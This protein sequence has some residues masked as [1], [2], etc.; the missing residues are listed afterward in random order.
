MKSELDC[1]LFYMW[2]AWSKDECMAIFGER[3]GEHIWNKWEKQ[4]DRR[5]LDGAPAPFYA[6]CDTEVRRKIIERAVAHYNN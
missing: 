5:G 1:Y 6:N 3:F 4:C 2:N